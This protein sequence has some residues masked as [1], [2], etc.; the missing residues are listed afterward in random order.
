MLPP[1]R[2]RE[3][4]KELPLRSDVDRV[5]RVILID[6]LVERSEFGHGGNQEVVQPIAEMGAVE[7]LLVTPQM[8][9][10][11]AGLRAQ[12]EGLVEISED[13]VPKWDYEYPFWEEC[14][15]EMHG[16]EVVFRRIA[17]PLHGDDEKT[18]DWI[19]TIE[20][21]AVVCSGSRRNVTM[22]EEWMSGGGALMRCS[23]RMG[24]P[25]LGICFG[26]QL[27]CHSLGG[28]IERAESMS[29]G[30]WEL[31]LNSHGSSDE[32]FSTRGSG[33][34]GAPV[35]LYSHQDHVTTVPESCLLLGSAEHNR[36]TAVRVLGEDGAGLPAWGVQ[37][38]PEAAKARVE[39][40]FEWGHISEEEMASFQREHD[41]AGVL[42]SFASVVHSNID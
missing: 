18:E 21:D 34:G 26:H 11:E 40:A 37:F 16:N 41:G 14:F 25:T 30:V 2:G 32:L 29:S 13:D 28:R 33:E 10:D 39:R 7:V 24:I 15:M 12:E 1:P 8:Q 17:M 38:H 31:A 5:T 4:F 27:L 6:L 22:W 19:R 9:S 35:A 3:S 20:P 42:N 36:V 23:S